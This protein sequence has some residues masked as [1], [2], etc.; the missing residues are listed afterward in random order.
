MANNN[1]CIKF[2]DGSQI[3]FSDDESF[4]NFIKRLSDVEESNFI[5][6]LDKVN[7][8]IGLDNIG[9]IARIK[10]LVQDKINSVKR[11]SLMFLQNGD[12]SESSARVALKD[13]FKKTGLPID[14]SFYTQDN[15][16]NKTAEQ[17]FIDNRMFVYKSHLARHNA[18]S[19]ETTYEQ[20]NGKIV[21]STPEVKPDI[22]D[23]ETKFKIISKPDDYGVILFEANPGMNP[24]EHNTAVSDYVNNYNKSFFKKE[25]TIYAITQVLPNNQ[26]KAIEVGSNGVLFKNSNVTGKK[27][28]SNNDLQ[29][30]FNPKRTKPKSKVKESKS[31][32]KEID[33]T[34][35]PVLSMSDLINL[36]VI[37]KNCY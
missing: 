5:L 34:V 12:Y 21:T 24:I 1:R 31:D 22:S 35:T 9:R 26:F 7:T 32:I 36:N 13:I 8:D 6:A 19:F 27:S 37:V 25:N 11:E 28:Y 17:L 4:V 33:N 15:T 16:K 29:L 14:S 2:S 18:R 20:K 10:K 30:F 23:G 3:T